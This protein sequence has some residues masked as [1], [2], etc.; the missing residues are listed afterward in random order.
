MTSSKEMAQQVKRSTT[1]PLDSEVT[2][3]QFPIMFIRKESSQKITKKFTN[4]FYCGTVD[5]LK[6]EFSFRT[7]CSTVKVLKD[8]DTTTKSKPKPMFKRHRLPIL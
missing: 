8:S 2:D 5:S 1:K 6:K 4:E 3:H 7:Q